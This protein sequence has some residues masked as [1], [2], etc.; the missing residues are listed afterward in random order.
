MKVSGG[1]HS[2]RRNPIIKEG[3]RYALTDKWILAQNHRTPKIQLLKHKKIKKEDQLMDT[4]YLPRLGNKISIEGVAETKFRAKTKGWT[5]QRL[6][7]YYCIHRQDFAERSL[8]CLSPVRLCQCL[9]NTEVD[10][11][12]HL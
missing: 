5:I 7:Q 11:H 8:I 3:T 9:A 12:I 4:S 1:Y 2:E 10:A 6:P